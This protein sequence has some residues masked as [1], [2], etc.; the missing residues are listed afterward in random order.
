M[1]DFEVWGLGF[2]WGLGFGPVW[3]LEWGDWFVQVSSTKGIVLRCVSCCHARGCRLNV[4]GYCVDGIALLVFKWVCDLYHRH[5]FG[6]IGKFNLSSYRGLLF[7][8]LPIAC[9]IAMVDFLLWFDGICR[10]WNGV[11]VL[12]GADATDK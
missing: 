2:E 6:G 1:S 9:R 7:V 8:W 4:C 10:V 11:A 12:P 3:G 5:R